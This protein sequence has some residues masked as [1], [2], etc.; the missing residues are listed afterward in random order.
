[1]CKPRGFLSVDSLS[2]TTPSTRK[3]KTNKEKDRSCRNASRLMEKVANI[4]DRTLSCY[5]RASCYWV[6]AALLSYPTYF[7]FFGWNLNRNKRFLSRKSS[8]TPGA[9]SLLKGASV[10]TLAT[11]VN[12]DTLGRDKG[13]ILG[14]H[15]WRWDQGLAQSHQPPGC[16]KVR[17]LGQDPPGQNWPLT[18][19]AS[20]KRKVG[21][22]KWL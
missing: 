9:C 11:K 16:R 7:F 4:P 15:G 22:F 2:R 10:C 5:R 20:R 13:G 14:F 6:C 18:L 21:L 8:L 1:M 12:T 19:L 17:P 3:S